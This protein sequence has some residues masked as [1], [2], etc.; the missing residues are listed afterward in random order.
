VNEI[1]DILKNGGQVSQLGRSFT[2]APCRG[3]AR[4]DLEVVVTV[5][6]VKTRI[7]AWFTGT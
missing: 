5:R 1:R 2:W 7:T 3:D 6:G 4:R